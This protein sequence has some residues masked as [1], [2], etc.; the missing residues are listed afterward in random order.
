MQRKILD[1]NF[2]QYESKSLKAKHSSKRLCQNTLLEFRT[3]F[4]LLFKMA[5]FNIIFTWD[6]KNIPLSG[7][8]LVFKKDY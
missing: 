1:I 3:S 5:R 8:S 7:Q 2:D 6:E 4:V